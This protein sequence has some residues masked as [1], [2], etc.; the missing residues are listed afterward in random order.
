MKRILIYALGFTALVSCTKTIAPQIQDK[1]RRGLID[2]FY[3]MTSFSLDYSRNDNMLFVRKPDNTISGPE[4]ETLR[5]KYGDTLYY[6]TAPAVKEGKFDSYANGFTAIAVTSGSEFNGTPAG[7]SLGD[8]IRIVGLSTYR[9]I[10]SRN[11][12]FNPWTTIPEDYASMCSE[13]DLCPENFPVNK[14]LSSLTKEDLA[15]LNVNNLALK[16]TE[17]PGIKEQKIK[18]T[19]Y[20]GEKSCSAERTVLFE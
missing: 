7:E 16:F 8:K 5:T 6:P 13:E 20:E 12:E 2:N 1:S 3:E 15:L 11:E 17:S 19:F 9:Y 4:K 18:V 10:K 14:S